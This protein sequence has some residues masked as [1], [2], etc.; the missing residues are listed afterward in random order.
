MYPEQATSTLQKLSESLSKR[1]KLLAL[2]EDAQ[3]KRAES[4]R[5]A[6]QKHHQRLES[7]PEIDIIV[8]TPCTLPLKE[9]RVGTSVFSRSKRIMLRLKS[10]LKGVPEGHVLIRIDDKIEVCG[11]QFSIKDVNEYLSKKRES[12]LVR[13]SFSDVRSAHAVAD[14]HVASEKLQLAHREIE[15]ASKHVS[16]FLESAESVISDLETRFQQLLERFKDLGKESISETC[17]IVE[18]ATRNLIDSGESHVESLNASYLN[19]ASDVFRVCEALDSCLSVGVKDDDVEV[20]GENVG[21]KV[22]DVEV[23]GENVSVRVDD[24]EICGEKV[25]V[26]ETTKSEAENIEFETTKTEAKK[27][28]LETTAEKIELE[29]T[30]KMKAEKNV[31][32]TIK[33]I[34]HTSRFAED[35]HKVTLRSKRALSLAEQFF[36][37]EL[38]HIEKRNIASEYAARWISEYLSFHHRF[39][40][41]QKIIQG[42]NDVSM[43]MR[44][45]ASEIRNRWETLQDVYERSVSQC[46]NTDTDVLYADQFEARTQW[47]NSRYRDSDGNKVD[48]PFSDEGQYREKLE[49]A[50]SRIAIFRSVLLNVTARK[51]RV[52]R[53]SLEMQERILL[54][55]MTRQASETWIDSMRRNLCTLKTLDER[56]CKTRIPFEILLRLLRDEI[57]ISSVVFSESEMVTQIRKWCQIIVELIEVQEY[58][59]S[60]ISY[61]VNEQE[62]RCDEIVYLHREKHVAFSLFK[63]LTQRIHSYLSQRD[64]FRVDERSSIR[65]QVC[66]KHKHFLNVLKSVLKN[67][68]VSLNCLVGSS[69]K[70]KKEDDSVVEYERAINIIRTNVVGCVIGLL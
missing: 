6:I 22:D 7:S 36:R 23:C 14:L 46:V 65:I 53:P 70:K 4:V 56:L 40:E 37:S 2:A 1:L 28:E 9:M 13:L 68:K 62:S 5:V 33:A 34:E 57:E 44:N 31:D 21:V 39:L 49:R 15:L 16:E 66:D 17:R 24:V 60:S 35:L 67:L 58:V 45:I 48:V 29:T 64:N 25:G 52:L 26:L 47:M 10:S 50:E 51:D 42:D 38:K 18:V 30:T 12:N 11:Q 69:K 63:D 3:H 19:V 27:I 55:F 32:E 8:S 41:R 54:K 61:L 20:C 43:E 59:V